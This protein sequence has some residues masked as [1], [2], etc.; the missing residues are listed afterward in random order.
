M[1]TI[2]N[3]LT[4]TSPAGDALSD[5]LSLSLTKADSAINGD[6]E[7]KLVTVGN[8]FSTTLNENTLLLEARTD[9]NKRSLVYFKNTDASNTVFIYVDSGNDRTLIAGEQVMEIKP[10]D[11][12]FFP[13]SGTQGLEA[14]SSANSPK[15]EVGVFEQE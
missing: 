14:A 3:T 1:A 10:G 15:L 6:V 11:F 5:A 8:R 9:T 7:M 4:I 13:W 2:T 12:A